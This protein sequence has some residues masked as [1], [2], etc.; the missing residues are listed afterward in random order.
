M[1]E[2]ADVEDGEGEADVAEVAGAAEEGVAAGLAGACFCGD[3]EAEVEGTG[4]G[5]LAGVDVVEGFGVDCDGAHL[6]DGVGGEDGEVDA[7]DDGGGVGWEWFLWEWFW[8]CVVVC[9]FPFG[10][11]GRGGH[12]GCLVFF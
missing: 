4:G 2:E 5:G 7:F 9:G 1:A 12:A 8:L 10:G 3:A 11:F 6:V